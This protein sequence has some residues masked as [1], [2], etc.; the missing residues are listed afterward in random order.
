M[1]NSRP[2]GPVKSPARLLTGRPQV[3]DHLSA[4]AAFERWQRQPMTA[5]AGLPSHAPSGTR[6]TLSFESADAVNGN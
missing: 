3:D 6:L 5:A 2:V 1:K 4:V